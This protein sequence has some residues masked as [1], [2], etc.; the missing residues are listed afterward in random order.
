MSRNA[1]LPRTETF[2]GRDV[3]RLQRKDVRPDRRP[4]EFLA[5]GILYRILG[6]QIRGEQLILRCERVE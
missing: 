6:S 1:K 3:E 2:R 4:D 5:D